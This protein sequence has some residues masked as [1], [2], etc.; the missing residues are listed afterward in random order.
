M[1]KERKITKIP[2][3]NS[4][5]LTQHEAALVLPQRAKVFGMRHT[6]D[7]HYIPVASAVIADHSSREERGVRCR[8]NTEATYVK[9]Q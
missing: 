6:G 3:I 1:L 7:T 8:F 4:P 9:N 5:Y 2:F